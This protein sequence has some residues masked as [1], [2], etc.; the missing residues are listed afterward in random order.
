[1]KTLAAVTLLFFSMAS[2]QA[3]PAAIPNR[4]NHSNCAQGPLERVAFTATRCCAGL[5]ACPQL[6]AN[7]G[8]V[9]PKRADRT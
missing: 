8:L 1:M 6:L 9:K 4:A 2:A 3:A 5:F 7:T